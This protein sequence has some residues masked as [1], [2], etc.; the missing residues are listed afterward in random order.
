LPF[1][2]KLVS[3]FPSATLVGIWHIHIYLYIKY[4]LG[5]SLFDCEISQNP[6]SLL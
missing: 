5:Y 3:S 4:K 6:L 1:A 2:L